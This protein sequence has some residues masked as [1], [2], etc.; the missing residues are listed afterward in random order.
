MRNFR[1]KPVE[2]IRT[3]ILLVFMG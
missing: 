3:H 1:T 2:K